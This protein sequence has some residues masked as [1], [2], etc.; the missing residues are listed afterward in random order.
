[1]LRSLYSAA[2]GLLS[3]GIQE[4]VV[5]DN[6]ANT[7][8][9]GYKARQAALATFAPLALSRV[10]PFA[11]ALSAASGLGSGALGTVTSGALVDVTGTDWSEGTLQQS[12]SPLAAAIDGPGFFAVATG[13]GVQYTRDGDFRFNAGGQ[14]TDPA[15]DVVLGANGQP[16]VAAG[17]ESSGAASIDDHGLLS[18]GGTAVGTVGVFAPPT[19][20]LS[21]AGGGLFTLTPGTAAP[22]LQ[23]GATIRPGY[24]EGSNVDLIGQMA[25][26]LQIQQAFTSDQQAVQTADSTLNTG[27]TEVGTIA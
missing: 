18:V 11:Q 7:G 27:I 2:A 25:S 22:G 6:L 3:T 19:N 8:T 20:A 14:L 26:L 21:S 13:Q 16:L 9:T 24:L 12:T 15:G 4:G 10:Q 1:M 23:A 5:A 17:G